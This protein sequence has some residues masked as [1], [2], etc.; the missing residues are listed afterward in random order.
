MTIG[1]YEYEKIEVKSLKTKKHI[2][3]K[4][5]KITISTKY[6]N[7]NNPEYPCGILKIYK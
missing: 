1:K 2:F 6:P 3:L 7:E 4:M 5:I